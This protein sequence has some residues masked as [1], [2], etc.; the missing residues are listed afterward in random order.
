MSYLP[1]FLPPERDRPTNDLP[2]WLRSFPLRWGVV[3]IG[4]GVLLSCLLLA[5][6]FRAWPPVILAIGCGVATIPLAYLWLEPWHR[7][8]RHPAD[9]KDGGDSGDDHDHAA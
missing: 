2:T 1:P 9:D 4:G 7:D 5:A 8:S 6:P 3:V